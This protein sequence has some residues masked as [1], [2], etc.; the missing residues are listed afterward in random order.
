ME[1]EKRDYRAMMYLHYRQGKLALDSYEILNDVFGDQGPSKS[2]V[3]RW[4]AE[5]KRGKTS[6][7]DDTRS[8]RPA[9]A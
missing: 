7:E 6:L 1:L 8:G 9:E 3:T 5:F 4:F 2:T